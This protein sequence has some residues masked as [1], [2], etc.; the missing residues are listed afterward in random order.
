MVINLKLH[1]GVCEEAGE[2]Q[3]LLQKVYGDCTR[4]MFWGKLVPQASQAWGGKQDAL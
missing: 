2:G 3:G 4:R 1:V